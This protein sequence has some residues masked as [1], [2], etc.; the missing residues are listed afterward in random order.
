MNYTLFTPELMDICIV[1]SFFVIPNK[2]TTNICAQVIGEE[3]L[4]VWGLVFWRQGLAM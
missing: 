1:S 4:F 3:G 2:V